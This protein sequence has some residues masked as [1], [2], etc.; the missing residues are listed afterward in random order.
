ME[1]LEASSNDPELT[2]EEIL[3]ILDPPVV[4]R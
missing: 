3:E 4:R 2:Q 1:E